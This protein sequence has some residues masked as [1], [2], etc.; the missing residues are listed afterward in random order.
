MQG[1]LSI[2]HLQPFFYNPRAELRPGA[3]SMTAVASSNY[4]IGTPRETLAYIY[5]H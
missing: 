2:A 3:A 5:E 1:A 4:Q